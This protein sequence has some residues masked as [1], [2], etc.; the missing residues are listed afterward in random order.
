MFLIT[1]KLLPDGLCGVIT[2]PQL[3]IILSTVIFIYIDIF[4]HL[5]NKEVLVCWFYTVHRLPFTVHLLLNDGTDN[6]TTLHARIIFWNIL[7]PHAF[8]VKTEMD[9]STL[10]SITLEF[11]IEVLCSI[12]VEDCSNETDLKFMIWCFYISFVLFLTKM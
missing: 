11:V 6:C 3:Q 4:I 12:G 5:I 7:S 1:T 8:S 10:Y 2:F 9:V